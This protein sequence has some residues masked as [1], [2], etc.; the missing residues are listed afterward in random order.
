MGLTI[1]Y[2]LKTG[3]ESKTRAAAKALIE[4]LHE[5]ARGLL[6]DS[7]T[8]VF[9]FA[10]AAE[11]DYENPANEEHRGLLIEATLPLK[12]H[13]VKPNHII[14]FVALPGEGCESASFGLS[15]YPPEFGPWN[16]ADMPMY[17]WSWGTFCKTQYA[18]NAENGGISNFLHCHLT[19]IE[20]LDY[21]KRELGILDSVTDEGHYWEK[22]DLKALVE[23]VG[24][25]WNGAVASLAT[26]IRNTLDGKIDS[27]SPNFDYRTAGNKT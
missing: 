8:E 5:R 1:H 23:R 3:T 9:E 12:N 18:A 17:N 14:A 10:G 13:R 6:F 4:K 2:S 19:V 27:G 25:E 21:A 22:R 15:H 20:M 16:D 7:V 26:L 24:G 11:C